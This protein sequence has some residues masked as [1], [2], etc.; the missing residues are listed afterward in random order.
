M[1]VVRGPSY[2]SAQKEFKVFSEVSLKGNQKPLKTP[3]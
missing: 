2:S 1:E 3:I